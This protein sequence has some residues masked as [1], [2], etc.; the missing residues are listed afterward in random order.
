M[1]GGGLLGP[2]AG[3]G[4]PHHPLPASGH[5]RGERGGGTKEGRARTGKS[6][7]ERV[8]GSKAMV[9]RYQEGSQ[10]RASRGRGVSSCHECFLDKRGPVSG[11]E[12]GG[13]TPWPDPQTPTPQGWKPRL[14]GHSHMKGLTVLWMCLCCLRPEDVANVFPQSG[15]AWARAPTCWE[16]MCRC[17]LLGSVNTWGHRHRRVTPHL[18]LPCGPGSGHGMGVSLAA[19]PLH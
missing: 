18:L 10:A 13:F 16:R 15:Q 19:L 14:G 3:P 8:R 6:R 2:S 11:E 1:G 9:K 4:F 5:W 7:H 12:P 17:R